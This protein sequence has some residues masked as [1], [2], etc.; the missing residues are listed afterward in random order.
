MKKKGKNRKPRFLVLPDEQVKGPSV[1]IESVPL[2]KG[3]SLAGV[4]KYMI[5]TWRRPPKGQWLVEIILIDERDQSVVTRLPH[6]VVEKMNAHR[7]SI[8][9]EC[10]SEA[11]RKAYQ[12]AVASGKAKFPPKSV[13]PGNEA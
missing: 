4:R 10:R 8:L 12:S 1:V 5:T 13:E 2:E 11:G 6:G 3:G 9:A 7:E